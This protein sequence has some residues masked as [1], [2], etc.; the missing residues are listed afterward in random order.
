[1]RKATEMSIKL[2]IDFENIVLTKIELRT[3]KPAFQSNDVI[4]KYSG[5]E[6]SPRPLATLLRNKKYIRILHTQRVGQSSTLLQLDVSV[7]KTAYLKV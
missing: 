3:L 2:T 4:S 7:F 6:N 5:R 1:M